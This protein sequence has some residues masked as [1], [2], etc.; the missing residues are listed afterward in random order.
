MIIIQIQL[1]YSNVAKP[2]PQKLTVTPLPKQPF[3]FPC[4]SEPY[5]Q[6]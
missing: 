5:L 4:L 6:W 1:F 2:G 3:Q